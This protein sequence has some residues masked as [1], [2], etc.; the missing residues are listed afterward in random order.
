M[1]QTATAIATNEDGCKSVRVK[2][3]FDNGSQRSY[4]TKIKSLK[5]KLNIKPKKT[6]VLHLNTFGERSY[7]KQKCEV[8]PLF[9]R[10]NENED[11]MISALRFPVICSPLSTRIEVDQYPH[12]RGLQLADS[13][14][15][16][17]CIDVLIGSDH[18]WDIVK[19][20]IV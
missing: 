11:I 12:L 19:G 8:L 6:E 9:L 13:S 20:D 10:S 4:I 16:N 1:L 3:L 7:R 5:S 15:S 18:Y 17:E 2:I 14:D